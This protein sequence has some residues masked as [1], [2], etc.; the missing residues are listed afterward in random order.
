MTIELATQDGI[1]TLAFARPAKKNAIT[2]QMYAQ[3]A[4]G[5][6]AAAED[7]AARCQPAIAGSS[8]LDAASGHSPSCEKGTEKRALSPA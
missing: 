5:L 7:P 2:A 8:R 1:A 3:L 6:A 4:D